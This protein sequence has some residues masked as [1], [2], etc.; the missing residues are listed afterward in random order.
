MY[1]PRWNRWAG[2][3]IAALCAAVTLAAPGPANAATF[4]NPTAIQFPTAT[5]PSVIPVT[6]LAGTVT[7]L[8]VTLLDVSHGFPEDID[9]LLVGPTGQKTVI[10][11]DACGTLNH[12]NLTFAVAAAAVLPPPPGGACNT[13]TYLPTNYG[14]DDDTY[15]G[16]PL[17]PYSLSLAVFN[18]TAP[19]GPWQLFV[20]DD[21]SDDFGQ[22]QGGWRL[23]LTTSASG[24]PAVTGQRAA[25][26][27]RCKKKKSRRARAKC[28]RKAR[29]LPA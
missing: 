11:S 16:A 4:S 19:N 21:K 20:N 17:G 29:K 26:L 9:I 14:G 22:I 7:D 13:G 6:G 8:S 15:P 3:A 28:R 27:K 10:M 24:A 23:D 25:A 5:Y 12:S 1:G 2:V 18:A